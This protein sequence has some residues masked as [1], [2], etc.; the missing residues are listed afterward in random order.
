MGF[1]KEEDTKNEDRIFLDREDILEKIEE[2]VRL[3]NENSDYYKLIVFYGMGGIGKTRLTD[4]IYNK[5]SGTMLDLHKFS[6][7]ILNGET[8]SSILIHIRS[9]FSH[10][11]HFDYVLFRYLDFINYD[12]VDR[13]RFEPII[14]KVITYFATNVDSN[15][16]KGW[17]RL[18]KIV[19]LLLSEYEQRVISKEEKEQVTKLLQGK[20]ED[21]HCYMAKVL[22][23]DIENDTK[24]MKNFFIFDAYNQDVNIKKCDWLKHFVNSFNRGVFIVTSREQLD[25]FENCEVDTSVIE[26]I[27]LDAIPENFIQEYLSAKNFTFEQISIIVEKTDGIP[28]FLDVAL[29]IIENEGFKRNTFVGVRSKRDLVEA[30]LSHLTIEEQNIVEYLA[31]VRLFNEEI[32][33]NALNF[34]NLSCLNHIFSEFKK[35]SIVRYVEEFNGIYKIHSILAKNISHLMDNGLRHKVINNYIEVVQARIITNYSIYND[36]KYSFILNIYEL[37]EEEQLPIDKKLSE[38]LLDMYFFLVDKSYEIEFARN[39]SNL[40]GKNRSTLKYIYW[41]I[42]A[43]LDRLDDIKKGLS[44]LELIPKEA[45]NFGKHIKSLQCD[46]NYLL[47][48]SG[49]YNEA[50]KNMSLFVKNLNEKELDERYYAKGVLYDCDMRMLR[51]KFDDSIS[52][53]LILKARLDDS[54]DDNLFFTINKAIGHNY[55]FNFM[56]DKAKRFYFDN[57]KDKNLDYFYT[58][59][60]ETECY[61]NPELVFSIYDIAIEENIKHNNHNNLGK[62]YYSMAI[63][64]IVKGEYS[65]AQKYIKKAHNEFDRTKYKAGNLFVLIVEAYLEYSKTK[66]ISSKTTKKL[67]EYIEYIDG[68]YE[69]LLLPIY[70][71]RED[72]K[73]IEKFKHKFEWLSYDET[74]ENIKKFIVQL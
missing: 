22:A 70:V 69:Y 49:K 7:E 20:I 43:N 64:K 16:F 60:C 50:E 63:S 52:D 2:I 5:Y 55:R 53:L 9:E 1:Y 67:Q 24:G 46:M 18:E 10:T 33:D 31:V 40:E 26:N 59:Y 44:E 11:P 35:S 29:K 32:Y 23:K 62:I 15:V 19:N 17:G 3:Y 65:V 14:H 51:G 73:E 58:V 45:C 25:W 54:R 68:I 72:D 48:I 42:Q 47:S 66:K 30:F 8:V 71:A 28:L 37:V 38:K 74:I 56:L 57:D 34:N 36:E 4:Q 27:S 61:F 39:F 6:M 21:L 41:Y 13:R 12:R